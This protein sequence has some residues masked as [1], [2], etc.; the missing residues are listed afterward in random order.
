VSIVEEYDTN[1]VG[2]GHRETC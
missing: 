1:D 2:Y